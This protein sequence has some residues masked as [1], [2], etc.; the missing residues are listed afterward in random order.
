VTEAGGKIGGLNGD[1]LGVDWSLAANADLF[2]EIDQLV[3]KLSQ[4]YFN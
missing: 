1:K 3:Y 4:K 2:D